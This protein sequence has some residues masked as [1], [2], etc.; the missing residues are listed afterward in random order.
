MSQRTIPQ[1]FETSVKK[2]AE[3]VLMWEKKSDHFEGSTYLAIR[4]AVY[5]FAAGLMS[6]GISKGDRIALI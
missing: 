2:Y 3:N 5:Q 1:L 4:D 6:M